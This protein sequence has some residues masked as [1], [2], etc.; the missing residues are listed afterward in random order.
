MHVYDHDDSKARDSQVAAGAEHSHERLREI[1]RATRFVQL[2]YCSL[3]LSWVAEF[4]YPVTFVEE[5][6]W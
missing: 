1:V 6:G 5:P 3:S 4:T 2:C